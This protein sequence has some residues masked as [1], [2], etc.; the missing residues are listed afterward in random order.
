MMATERMVRLAACDLHFQNLISVGSHSQF[1]GSAIGNNPSF[2]NDENSV[3]CGF[4]FSQNMGTK[5]DSFFPSYFPNQITDFSNLIGVETRCRLIQNQYFR[6]MN[7]CLSQPDPLFVSFRKLSP[8][9]PQ[10]L[11]ISRI[12]TGMSSLATPCNSATKAR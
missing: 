5:N 9:R 4:H 6:V 12:R 11:I 7:Q 3:A 8:A 2:I 10:I 1:G